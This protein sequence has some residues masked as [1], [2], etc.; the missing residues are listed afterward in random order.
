[1]ISSFQA[2]SAA[3]S[4]LTPPIFF[5][6]FT[7]K[8]KERDPDPRGDLQPT[9]GFG[10]Q[11]DGFSWIAG[12]KGRSFDD[13]KVSANWPRGIDG[14][15]YGYLWLDMRY[16][17]LVLYR[18]QRGEPTDGIPVSPCRM[19]WPLKTLNNFASL[20]TTPHLQSDQ[21]EGSTRHSVSQKLI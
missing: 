17:P 2:R 4:R 12:G 9:N 8:D 3:R 7:S 18:W 1:M 6:R 11:G 16:K 19:R 13:A 15:A 14:S 20:S 21:H 10:G 5:Q